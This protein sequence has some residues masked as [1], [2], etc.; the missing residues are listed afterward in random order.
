[1]IM[2]DKER[3]LLHKKWTGQI[4]PEELSQVEALL[5]SDPAFRKEASALESI[6]AKAELP[7]SGDFVPDAAKAWAR[8]KKDMDGRAPVVSKKPPRILS[9]IPLSLAGK[10]AAA[11]ALFFLSYFIFQNFQ[12]D[13][14]DSY[15][16]LIKISPHSE[17]V[18][19]SLELPDGSVVWINSKTTF[20]YPKSFSGNERRVILE[21][22]AHFQVQKNPS[23]PFI[24]QT[25]NGEVRVLGT[26]FN[27]KAARNAKYE[28]VFVESGLVAFKPQKGDEELRLERGNA[29]RLKKSTL[30]L[31]EPS[32]ITAAE[33]LQWKSEALNFRNTPLK[34]ILDALERNTP[35]R[36]E[37]AKVREILHC[38]FTISL[39][40]ADE[41]TVVNY[42][43]AATSMKIRLDVNSYVYHLS[44]GRKCD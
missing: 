15:A 44:G 8:F 14:Q 38:P 31:I 42:L 26:A 6:W 32:A 25:P 2:N 10:A 9:L 43:E 11:V 40:G 20:W 39:E 18:M 36:F 16:G 4:S 28:E 21:G 27:V 34:D 29:A 24:V 17:K 5:S 7:A 33:V 30:Q 35:M 12:S 23:K 1:M 41:D 3:L 22:E 37:R 13:T 19:G